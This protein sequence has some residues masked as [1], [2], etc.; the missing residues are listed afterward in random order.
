MSE[1]LTTQQPNGTI[2]AHF[3]CDKKCVCEGLVELLSFMSSKSGSIK[4]IY[5]MLR[6]TEFFQ[7]YRILFSDIG[8]F[9]TFEKFKCFF[10]N[11]ALQGLLDYDV[12]SHDGW[13]EICFPTLSN[14]QITE[15]VSKIGI[16]PS[17][18]LE[19][20]FF[21]LLPTEGGNI[22]GATLYQSKTLAAFAG[23]KNNKWIRT[24]IENALRASGVEIR[25]T[26]Q[27]IFVFP[28]NWG[29]DSFSL[30][31]S[32]LCLT[33][34]V[35]EI[36][37][38]ESSSFKEEDVSTPMNK[39]FLRLTDFF[40]RNT[41]FVI[42]SL[43]QASFYRDICG[44]SREAIVNS[45]KEIFNLLL[46]FLFTI[47]KTVATAHP[48][49][50]QHVEHFVFAFMKII[51]ASLEGIQIRAVIKSG[52]DWIY[53]RQTMYMVCSSVATCHDCFKKN[54][55][56]YHVK[57]SDYGIVSSHTGLVMIVCLEKEFDK[58]PTKKFVFNDKLLKSGVIT[59]ESSHAV[60]CGG[61]ADPRAHAVASGGSAKPETLAVACG[62]SA[63]PRERTVAG[64]GSAKP[65]TLA[66]AG[67]GSADPRALAVAGG[68]SAEPETHAV[69][70]GGSADPRALAVAGGDSDEKRRY[71]KEMLSLM[72]TE[73]E[74][75]DNPHSIDQHA[76]VRFSL[77]IPPPPESGSHS[78]N[79]AKLI[80]SQTGD[81][82][83]LL[84]TASTFVLAMKAN[85]LKN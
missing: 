66:V 53:S 48:S 59:V 1:S 9:G 2:Y 58:K 3:S 82:D 60:A 85:N 30:F 36:P 84:R 70:C 78:E 33:L 63:K 79:I 51:G 67:G 21:E 52:P 77:G 54:C 24:L 26:P 27:A 39:V 65:E 62:G 20:L 61:S 32:Q 43:N 14:D 11:L 44:L 49:F 40:N 81:S 35:S 55:D 34:G 69:A 64:G 23:G 19:E 73:I 4:D 6:D 75:F 47:D 42:Q 28:K 17:I 5:S 76:V 31:V 12:E 80:K 7:K 38:V 45:T 56:F 10:T 41:S 74:E 15:L 18:R 22:E 68:G 29:N 16:T 57:T 8:P 71:A 13:I 25:K 46:Q 50:N 37:Y 83:A 72:M